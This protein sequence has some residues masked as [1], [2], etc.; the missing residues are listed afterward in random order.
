[1]T[2]HTLIHTK[3]KQYACTYCNKTFSLIQYL[4]EHTYTHTK[5]RPYM[6]GVAGCKKQF[7]QAGKLS[8]HRRTHKEYI[9]KAYTSRKLDAKESLVHKNKQSVKERNKEASLG[10]EDKQHKGLTRKISGHTTS[11]TNE[12]REDCVKEDMK[13]EKPIDSNK[14][15]IED[16]AGFFC[17]LKII[18]TSLGAIL[19][20]KLPLPL[21]EFW[22]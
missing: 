21:N 16:D 13:K 5:D 18:N 17:Y 9:L 2:R 1:M 19:R 20:P 7:R 12:E 6:C 15:E 8:I 22:K 11:F 4:K 10:I 3:D 14:E